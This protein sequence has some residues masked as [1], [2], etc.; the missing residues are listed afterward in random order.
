MRERS[1]QRPRNPTA[2]AERMLHMLPVLGVAPPPL[3]RRPP[4]RRGAVAKKERKKGPCPRPS[5]TDVPAPARRAGQSVDVRLGR[6]PPLRKKERKKGALPP[7]GQ[8]GRPR[9]VPLGRSER[10]RPARPV[11][12]AY[13]PL[14]GRAHTRCAGIV[15]RLDGI[16][17]ASRTASIGHRLT[18]GRKP[19]PGFPRYPFPASCRS[20]LIRTVKQHGPEGGPAQS[21]ETG[22]VK[23]LDEV[24]L[25]GTGETKADQRH[26]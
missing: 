12:P 22:L 13:A 7:P 20:D 14:P 15:C 24:S 6:S 3:R 2:R 11:S 19:V 21:D 1:G 5:R 23:G 9:T 25:G 26:G 17:G 10:G 8:T 16:E 18:A 4:P